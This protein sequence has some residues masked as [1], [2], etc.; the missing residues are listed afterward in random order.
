MEQATF[1]DEELEYIYSY[2]S[3]SKNYNLFRDI[4]KKIRKQ[5]KSYYDIDKNNY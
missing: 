4:E 3:C 1:T 5:I 2:L